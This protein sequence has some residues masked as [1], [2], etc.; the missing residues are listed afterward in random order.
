MAYQQRTAALPPKAKQFGRGSL[1]LRLRLHDTRKAEQGQGSRR[2]PWA[3]K[4]AP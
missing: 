3:Q 2:R 4:F 1:A